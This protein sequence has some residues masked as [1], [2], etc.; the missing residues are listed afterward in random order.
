[1]AFLRLKQEKLFYKPYST[2]GRQSI[3]TLC[4]E[5]RVRALSSQKTL[6]LDPDDFVVFVVRPPCGINEAV[7]FVDGLCPY[8]SISDCSSC[9]KTDLDVFCIE[10]LRD[11][12]QFG[13]A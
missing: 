8:S 7:A 6:Q 11:A 4:A 10:C 9:M 2:Q 13:L 1:M 12:Q 3:S 5:W